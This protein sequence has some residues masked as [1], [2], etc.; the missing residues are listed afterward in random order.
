MN[1]EKKGMMYYKMDHTY[2]TSTNPIRKTKN[3]R[4]RRKEK[5]EYELIQYEYYNQ[6]RT[7]VGKENNGW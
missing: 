6:R 5:Y 4:K 7:A 2:K 1:W 3:D